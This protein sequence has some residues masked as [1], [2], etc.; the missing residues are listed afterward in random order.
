[1]MYHLNVKPFTPMVV[2]RKD[3]DILLALYYLTLVV[4]VIYTLLI[5]LFLLIFHYLLSF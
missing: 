2:M 3:A 5:K 1:M 4:L